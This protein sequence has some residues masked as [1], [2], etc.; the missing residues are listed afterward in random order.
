MPPTRQP[1][2]PPGVLPPFTVPVLYNSNVH[3][4]ALYELDDFP[5]PV[6]Q[7]RLSWSHVLRPTMQRQRAYARPDDPLDELFR[8]LLRRQ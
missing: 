2:Y 5:E 4:E 6:H 1:L 8:L 3:A 7:R